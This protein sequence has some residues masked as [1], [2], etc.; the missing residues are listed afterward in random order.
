LHTVIENVSTDNC[1]ALQIRVSPA[2]AEYG[3]V[4]WI[5]DVYVAPVQNLEAPKRW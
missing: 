5:D 1:T 3:A 2:G 4:A